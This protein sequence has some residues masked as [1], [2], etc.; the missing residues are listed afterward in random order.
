MYRKVFACAG[1]S[2]TTQEQLRRSL[3]LSRGP[4]ASSYVCDPRPTSK[5]G[6]FAATLQE[7]ANAL[8]KADLADGTRGCYSTAIK[9]YMVFMSDRKKDHRYPKARDI[10][11]WIAEQSLFIYP[12]SL[13]RYIA[14]VKYPLE[15]FGTAGAASDVLGWRR[16]PITI[17]LYGSDPRKGRRTIP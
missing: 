11:M 12:D 10:A 6:P 17:Q 8:A 4:I 16:E 14:G 5:D 7:R 2:H 3:P 1:E 9:H 15:T 13:C